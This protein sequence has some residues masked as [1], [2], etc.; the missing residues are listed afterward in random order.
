MKYSLFSLKSISNRKPFFQYQKKGG[1]K[2]Y[3]VSGRPCRAGTKCEKNHIAGFYS[4]E[5]EGGEIGSWDFCCRDDHPCG[6]SRDFEY[7][8]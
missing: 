8:W 7:S 2:H 1:P 3:S 6:F 4:C 5:L